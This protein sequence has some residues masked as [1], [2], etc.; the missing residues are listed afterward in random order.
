MYHRGL[1]ISRAWISL[2]QIRKGVQH[3]LLNLSCLFVTLHS[4]QWSIT[5]EMKRLLSLRVRL[6]K[7]CFNSEG[8]TAMS[9]LT[10]TQLLHEMLPNVTSR[11][12]PWTNT[13]RRTDLDKCTNMK[14]PTWYKLGI[15]KRQ[16][17]LWDFNLEKFNSSFLAFGEDFYPIHISAS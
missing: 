3:L 14:I 17:I 5:S 6:P 4:F 9:S 1:S 8:V 12:C 15:I 7:Y 2:Q 13:D 10:K 16:T 11:W